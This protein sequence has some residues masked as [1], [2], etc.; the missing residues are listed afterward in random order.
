MK[1]GPIV[2]LLL[3][4]TGCA[5]PAVHVENTPPRS[6]MPAVPV[7]VRQCFN[8]ALGAV[9]ERDMS[10]AEVETAWKS[11]RVRFAVMRRCGKRFLA[12]YDDLRA[13][14]R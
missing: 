2:V 5:A 4:L 3:L 14:W 13:R 8:A 7:D 1:P 10:V 9:P 11:D 6:G 12:W